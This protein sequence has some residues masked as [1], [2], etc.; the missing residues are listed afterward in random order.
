MQTF[1]PK[2]IPVL[3]TKGPRKIHR[4][5]FFI[6]RNRRERCIE[7]FESGGFYINP[8]D[9]PHSLRFEEESVLQLTC[10]GP[11]VL[12]LVE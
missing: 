1:P 9:V 2:T 11:W 4:G 10:E 8:P 7:Q 3:A 6:A 5:P 12:K